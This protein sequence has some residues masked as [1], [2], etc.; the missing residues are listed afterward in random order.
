MGRSFLGW[1]GAAGRGGEHNLWKAKLHCPKSTRTEELCISKVVSILQTLWNACLG[2]VLLNPFVGKRQGRGRRRERQKAEARGSYLGASTNLLSVWACLSCIC[3]PFLCAQKIVK[4]KGLGR[5]EHLFL[6]D[7]FCH[8]LGISRWTVEVGGKDCS[9]SACSPVCGANSQRQLD[10][11]WPLATCLHLGSITQCNGVFVAAVPA[12]PWSLSLRA[13]ERQFPCSLTGTAQVLL[14]V[15]SHIRYQKGGG[16]ISLHLPA[17]RRRPHNPKD[18][19]P[20]CRAWIHPAPVL[21]GAA[22]PQD[23]TFC[24]ISL[25][26][27]DKLLSAFPF[28]WEKILKCAHCSLVSLFPSY[29]SFQCIR[30]PHIQYGPKRACK[31][32]SPSSQ[33]QVRRL[34]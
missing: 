12:A 14:S 8:S 13:A 18:V 11:C 28:P 6:F 7:Y 1:V 23:T 25:L 3:C 24:P 15:L 33:S 26:S 9:P 34:K 16:R 20:L 17:V 29:F 2:C 5:E 32:P 21:P 22:I 10:S 19:L 30:K 27:R 31:A 4:N